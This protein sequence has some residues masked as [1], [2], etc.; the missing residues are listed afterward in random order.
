MSTETASPMAGRDWPVRLRNCG[1]A[2]C[3]DHAETTPLEL[4][5]FSD[6][7]MYQTGRSYV[8]SVR[9]HGTPGCVPLARLRRSGTQSENPLGARVYAT[10][11]LAE[12]AGE[13]SLELT[14]VWI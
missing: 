7:I 3:L 14:R 11:E 8:L 10:R 2:C 1:P 12:W 13:P 5:Q 6:A 9:S 4:S